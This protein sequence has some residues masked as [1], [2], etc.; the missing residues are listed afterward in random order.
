MKRV[1]V[2]D[3]D[4]TLTDTNAVDDECFLRAA[5][6]VLGVDLGGADWSGAPHVT[7]AA[8]LEWLCEGHCGRPLRGDEVEAAR[9]VFLGLLERE[10][11]RSPHRFLPI[12]GAT[13]VF[14]RLRSAGW[15]VAVATG[16]WETSAR[17]KLQAIGVDPHLL[18]MASS[19]DARTRTEILSLALERFGDPRRVLTRVVSLGDGVW[20]VGAALAL[21]LPF[22]G[23]A[24]GARAEKLRAAGADTIL[25]DLRDTGRLVHALEKAAVPR[26]R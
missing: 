17:L 22:V 7:D 9:R 6:E 26:R 20:D 14:A 24:S 8:L 18:T 13:D 25:E 1:A 10:L 3:I 12:P 21:E 5:G 15:E 16:G 23:I 19:S 4:G 11:V 2:F